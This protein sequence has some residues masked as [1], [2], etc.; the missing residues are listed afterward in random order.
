MNAKDILSYYNYLE[1][2]YYILEHISY[3]QVSY[4]R[5]L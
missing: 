4:S 3:F 2:N 1:R 5:I